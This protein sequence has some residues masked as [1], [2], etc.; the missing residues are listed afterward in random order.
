M[1]NILSNGNSRS[2][3]KETQG[4]GHSQGPA[5]IHYGPHIGKARSGGRRKAKEY[6]KRSPITNGIDFQSGSSV[7]ARS[8]TPLYAQTPPVPHMCEECQE[9]LLNESAAELSG[10]P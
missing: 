3:E 8:Y 10:Q 2:K 5:T 7:M 4:A 6:R 1:K 9:Y